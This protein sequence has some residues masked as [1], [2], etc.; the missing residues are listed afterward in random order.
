M[1]SKLFIGFSALLATVLL[2]YM[3]A[4]SLAFLFGH[5]IGSENYNHG[6]FVPLISLFLIWQARHRI[7]EAGIENSWW[8]LAVIS[9][10]LFLYW[11]GEFATLYV[12]EHVSL[13]MVIVGLVIALMGVR[14]SLGEARAWGRV[15]SAGWGRCHLAIARS[16]G[17]WPQYSRAFLVRW[18]QPCLLL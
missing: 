16:R 18:L 15:T 3:Y 11:I 2:G 5:W 13:W 8:G 1:S 6:M 4:D 14:T 17:D 9:A 12:L 7:A 10:G